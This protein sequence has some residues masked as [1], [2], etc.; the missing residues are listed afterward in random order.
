MRRRSFLS[1]TLLFLV[2]CSASQDSKTRNANSNIPNPLRFMVTDAINAEQLE[3]YQPFRQK[4]ADLIQ[5]EVEFIPV[6]SYMA[7]TVALQKGEVDLALTGP[8]E[9]VTIRA[10][11]N[12]VPMISLSR[13]NYYSIIVKKAESEIESLSDLQGKTISMGP[14]GSTSS[15]LGPTYLLMKAGLNP[16]TDVKV[17]SLDKAGLDALVAGEVVAWCG[18]FTDY[19]GFLD[20]QNLQEQDLPIIV[21]G[22]LLP[23]DI[24]VGSSQLSEKAIAQISQVMLDQEQALIETLINVDDGKY[25][26][27]ELA[28]AND[29]EYDLI[30]EVYKAVGEGNFM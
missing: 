30:R 20:A 4:L 28:E 15:Y 23:G 9:Y 1:Y 6:E 19:Q 17:Q 10:R 26:N 21:Q 3:D 25:R 18:S 8:S 13:P 2:S 12:A 29:S 5:Q 27:A 16:K 22:Q 7:A 24:F 11:T 14:V